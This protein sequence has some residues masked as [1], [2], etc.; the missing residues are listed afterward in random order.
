METGKQRSALV[1]ICRLLG[2]LSAV[3]ALLQTLTIVISFFVAKNAGTIA[4]TFEQLT[5][6]RA[7]GVFVCLIAALVLF[8]V[9][10]AVDS[11]MRIARVSE[12][13]NEL[14]RRLTRDSGNEPKL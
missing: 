5:V 13:T 6:G 7:F 14:L 2:A 1:F 11:F 8:G 9:A 4:G 3:A 10:R 12:D